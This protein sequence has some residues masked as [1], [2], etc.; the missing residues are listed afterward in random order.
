MKTPSWFAI[1]IAIAGFFL[2]FAQAAPAPQA[3]WT[4]MVYMSGDNNLEDYIVKD[5]ELELGLAGS[6][7]EIQVVALADRG[8][9]YDTSRGNW[10]T[11]QLY[12]V[13]Q[14]I[15]AD[16][17]SA[18]ADWGE[19][20]FG[21]PQTLVDFVTWSKS[22]YPADHYALYFWGHGWNWHPGWVMEDDTDVDTLDYHEQKAAIPQLGFIDVVGYDGCNMATLELYKLWQNKATAIAASEEYVGWNGIEYDSVIAQLRANPF[23]SAD[24]VAVASAQSAVV[25]GGERTFSAVAVDA[26]LANLLT[27]TEQFAVALTNGLAANRKKYNN[28]FGATRSMWQAPMD[29]DLY[30]MAHEINSAISDANIKA[31]AQGV[32][33]AISSVTLY[34]GHTNAYADVHGMT[35]YH[36][37]KASQ[38]DSN[39]TYYRSTIDL[40]LTTSW[41]EFLNAYAQ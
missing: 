19:R 20:N 32:M 2:N 4:I 13:T 18:V 14:G 34:E 1:G 38:K 33:N 40:A 26:R 36:I 23:M 6:N 21:D 11:T 17:A 7:A 25:L 15:L 16:P 8:P 24:Q 39:Y 29:K 9:G 27:A 37:S 31:R 41:D 22:N 3:R 5:I 12:H 28:A 10:Q 30:D 35:I